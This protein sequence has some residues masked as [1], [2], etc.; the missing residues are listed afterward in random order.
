M[1]FLMTYGHLRHS[2]MWIP[3]TGIAGRILQSPAHHQLHHSA[4]PAHFDKN[5]GFALALWDWAFGTLAIPARTRE[6]IVFGVGDEGA[7]FRSALSALVA[8]V[9]RL[10]GHALRLVQRASARDAGSAAKTP[11]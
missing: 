9:G 8:P 5:L 7:P 10:S 6:P 3:F 2:H 4:N 11:P 1:A